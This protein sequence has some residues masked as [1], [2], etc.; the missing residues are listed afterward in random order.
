VAKTETH[1]IWPIPLAARR[2]LLHPAFAWSGFSSAFVSIVVGQK[3]QMDLGTVDALLASIIGSWLLFIYSGAIG[4]AGGRWGL[5]FQLMLAAVFGRAGAILPS[6]MFAGLVAGWFGFHVVLT[7]TVLSDWLGLSDTPVACSLLLG[8]MFAAPVISGISHGFNMTAVALPAMLLFA[9]IVFSRIVMPNWGVLLDGPLSGTLSFG[10]GVT[11]VFGMFVVSGTMTG[12]I[13]RYCRTGDEAVQVMA[14]GF[15]FSN[16]PFLILGVLVGAAQ[17]DPTQ[18]MWAGGALSYLLLTLVVIS[19]LTTSDACLANASVT[20]KTAFPR[21]PWWLLSAGA[22]LMGVMLALAG[23]TNRLS[24]WVMFLAAVAPP[25]GSIIVADYYVVRANI[26]FSRA[27]DVRF[28][29]AA[30]IALG[31]SIVVSLIVWWY[32]SDF[33]TPLIG[34]PLA[35]CLYLVLATLAPNELGVGLGRESSGAEAVD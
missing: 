15:V 30:L 13:V 18:L 1:Q 33:A 21:I 31:L 11:I 19:T 26:G 23:L 4:F 6:L 5:N 32:F 25:V 20:L 29:I 34:A 8:F 16:L 28:N 9:I 35:G 3:L 14:A 17:V 22:A 7:M 2:G 27:R 12:D 24:G 10:T